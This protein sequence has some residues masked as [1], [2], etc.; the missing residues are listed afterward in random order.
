MLVFRLHVAACA[1]TH[2]QALFVI[3][4]VER[5]YQ[6]MI[7]TDDAATE[8]KRLES[9]AKDAVKSQKQTA[10]AKANETLLALKKVLASADEWMEKVSGYDC[11]CYFNCLFNCDEF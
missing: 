9:L 7:E 4:D 11:H 6:R 5:T 2:Q 10:R 1:S 8:R 3:E